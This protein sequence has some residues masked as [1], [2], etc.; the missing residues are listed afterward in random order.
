MRKSRLAVVA[1]IIVV[2]VISIYYLSTTHPST[3]C[4]TT[5]TTT[6]SNTCGP[7]VGAFL[8][9]WYGGNGSQSGLGSP[10][11]N[12]SSYPG[13]GEVVDKP[14][15]GYYS[16][17]SDE[18]FSWQVSQMER[19]GLSFAVVS[20]WGPST[21]NETGMIN[22]AAQDLFAY[23]KA[24]DS[25]FK[26]AI[27]VDA[28]N[29]SNNLSPS[30]LKGD[31]D[32]VY[33]D[34]VRPYSS[35]YFTWEGKPLLLFY[36]P[37][38]PTYTNDSYTVRT[39]GNRPN[40]VNWTFWDAPAQYFQGQAGN[41]NA[42]NDEDQP[43][44]STDGEVTLV[45]RI[46]SY[47]DRGYQNG[48]YLRFDSNLSEGLYQ[49]QWS[50]VLNNTS[51][52]KLVLIYSWNEYHERTSIEPHQD[53]TA[54]VDSTYLSDLT[55]RYVAPVVAVSRATTYL[56]SNYNPT[57]GLISETPDSH[58]YWLYSDNYLA[59][60]A[61][62]QVGFSNP[63][64]AAI[65]DNIS[66]T[67]GFYAPRLVGAT[68]QYMVLSGAWTGP[69]TFDNTS[70]HVLTRSSN[71][72]IAVTLNNGTG[73]LNASDYADIAFLAAICHQHQG[74]LGMAVS[75]FNQGAKFFDG[76][77]FADM[78]FKD[79]GSQGQYQTYK[80]A[81]YIYAG[82][83]LSQPVNQAAMAAL[84]KM[85]SPNGGFYTGYDTTFSHGSSKTNAETTSLAILALLGLAQP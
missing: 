13:G 65:A 3:T 26:V 6:T 1:V 75:A 9:L 78:Q 71:P 76:I 22:K 68:N 66:A 47:F 10:G 36:N 60:L 33:D 72:Q 32:Y 30:S 57:V 15:I 56:T 21:T 46:D 37:I 73:I 23:L 51:E 84:L 79:P 85:Q 28:Y 12:S 70:S 48:S 40:P 80:L 11:W 5:S 14:A 16:S 83:L 58:T 67:I 59:V 61:L 62:R 52:V 35:W 45:P 17:D 50:F 55:I 43:V 18:T 25:S 24:S 41:V 20:W 7:P 29:G 81:L 54:R 39:I 34:F 38:Y 53:F 49:D 42:T 31:Y 77:G 44:I 64:I 74:N 8:Y 2:L 27:L 4:P 82:K 19:A 63:Y 69:C